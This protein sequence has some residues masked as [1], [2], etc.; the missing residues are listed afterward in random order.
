VIVLTRFR[1]PAAAA[2]GFRRQAEDAVAVLERLPGSL[3]VD[4][5]RNLDDPAKVKE[6]GGA[7]V[8]AVKDAAEKAQK[9]AEQAKKTGWRLGVDVKGDGAGGV[10][11]SITVT[12]TFP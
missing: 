4:L 8:G 7:L 5:A 11:G 1:V 9:S 10:S 3:S 6:H 2:A 12:W